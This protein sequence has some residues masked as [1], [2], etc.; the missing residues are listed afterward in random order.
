MCDD[1]HV[2]GQ[3]DIPR[4]NAQVHLP[5]G[6]VSVVRQAR[7]PGTPVA[8]RT[9]LA[10]THPQH[11]CARQIYKVF[12]LANAY[13]ISRLI[14][15]PNPKA[16]GQSILVG[17]EAHNA[18]EY[19]KHVR[20]YQGRAWPGAL[21]KFT[22]LDETPHK[23]PAAA[24][25]EPLQAESDDGGLVSG[26]ET[27]TLSDVLQTPVPAPPSETSTLRPAEEV[28]PVDNE[29]VQILNRIFERLRAHVPR[30]T[31]SNRTSFASTAT[32]EPLF[33]EVTEGTLTLPVSK[34]SVLTGVI[35]E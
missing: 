21:L 33:D 31:P 7:Q 23:R 15:S 14:F 25:A 9:A 16:P 5:R 28:L 19:D 35:R 30:E 17:L 10:A 3:S 32:A 24:G 26:S 2:L 34:Y 8:A 13:Y 18:D 1:G 22:V 6:L 11:A 12:P 29:R 4:G 20:Q 27:V